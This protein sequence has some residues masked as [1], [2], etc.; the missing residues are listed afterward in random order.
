MKK[1]L[2]SLLITSLLFLSILLPQ[3]EAI[4]KISSLQ[5]GLV[6]HWS[7][8][9][10]TGAKD[11]TP[12]GNN[13]TGAGSITIGGATDRHEQANRATAL[14]NNTQYISLPTTTTVAGKTQVTI[15]GWFKASS[16]PSEGTPGILWGENTSS[17]GFTRVSLGLYTSGG[18]TK[19]RGA[20]RDAA[21]DPAGTA[22][23]IVGTT[24]LSTGTWY[25]G[26]FVFDS[27]NDSHVV[28]LNKIA[29]TTNTTAAGA[30]GTTSSAGINIGR[31]NDVSQA[32]VGSISDVRIY[33]RALSATEITSLYNSY[34]PKVA[35]SSLQKGLVGH[36]KLDQASNKS[37]TVTADATP[38]GN[39]G[40]SSGSP[41]LGGATDQ[42]GQANRA[43][44]FDGTDD[45]VGLGQV[46]D[47]IGDMSISLWVKKDGTDNGWFI[48]KRGAGGNQFQWWGRPNS[49]DKKQHLWNGISI[50]DS[51]SNVSD[52]IWH[53]VAV[54]RSGTTI[55][56]YLDGQA[57]GIQTLAVPA[58]STSNVAIQESAGDYA[59]GSIADVRI[60]NRALSATEITSLY[61]SY[62]PKITISSL[63]KG[64]V[65]S[66][67]LAQ[68]SL[69]GTDTMADKTPQGNNLTLVNSPTSATDRHGQAGKALTFNGSTQ[70]A[71]KS[72][73]DYR[74]GDS[75]G[76]VSAW[77][78]ISGNQGT[79]RHIFGN[80][81]EG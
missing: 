69:I 5:K 53:Y 7:L 56:F 10:I 3:S 67:N 49:T 61:N 44:T 54:V 68:T 19:I 6:G 29:E 21:N 34:H 15:A 81:D 58:S 37:T 42:H 79:A 75:Q 57:D 47:F 66:W 16:F 62:R 64:L 55:I 32:F 17:I 14:A 9:N 24:S 22:V 63:Q 73:A 43:T 41:T 13:G 33:N 39:N 74:S 80:R 35:I 78:K 46:A 50:V 12:Y 2:S 60:Y 25:H 27:V 52:N 45:Y 70:Y 28:Y 23:T 26:V 11:L 40:T 51:N 4:I 38:Y 8:D 76:T 30:L 48:S 77:I 59:N 65:G 20:Y 31:L 71:W 36:W 1:L 72:I 18:T